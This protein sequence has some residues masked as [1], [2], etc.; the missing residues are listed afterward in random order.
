MTCLI[1]YY[2]IIII[3]K[4]ICGAADKHLVISTEKSL[5]FNGKNIKTIK[6]L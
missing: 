3:S 5:I 6:Q 4:H 2:Q 1:D